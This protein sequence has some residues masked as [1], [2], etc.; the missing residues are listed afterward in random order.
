MIKWNLSIVKPPVITQDDFYSKRKV[1]EKVVIRVVHK[2]GTFCGY[3]FARYHHENDHWVIEQYLGEF[4]VTH[5]T[6]LNEPDNL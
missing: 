3:A 2:N 5:W 6:E 1:S 4:V